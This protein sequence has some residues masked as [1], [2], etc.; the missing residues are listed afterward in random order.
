MWSCVL[1]LGLPLKLIVRHKGCPQLLQKCLG[2]VNK[3]AT[4]PDMFYSAILL[5]KVNPMNVEKN[6]LLT[7]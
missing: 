1:H 2:D 7:G 5:R 4:Y 6:I 3:S